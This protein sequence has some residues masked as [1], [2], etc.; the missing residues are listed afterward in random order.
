MKLSIHFYFYNA[1]GICCSVGDKRW[2]RAVPFF[3]KRSDAHV[4]AGEFF[5]DFMHDIGFFTYFFLALIAVESCVNFFARIEKSERKVPE[6]DIV[7]VDNVSTFNQTS[8]RKE[9]FPNN[10]FFSAFV[11]T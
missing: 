9:P 7:T 2:V 10:E 1:G 6:K 11:A 3:Q 5:S 4:A 8:M